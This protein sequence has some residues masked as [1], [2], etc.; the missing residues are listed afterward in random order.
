MQADL[1]GTVSVTDRGRPLVTS[2]NGT[3]M[4]RTQGAGFPR[5][6]AGKILPR[7]RRTSGVKQRGRRG[8]TPRP[9]M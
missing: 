9:A 5:A 4:A 2:A 6:G 1:R 7:P 3:L 8:H